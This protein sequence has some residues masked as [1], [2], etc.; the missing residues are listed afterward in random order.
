VR[1]LSSALSREGA[2]G[3]R[4]V[5]RVL[6]GE[7]AHL[8]A[9]RSVPVRTFESLA[10]V[11]AERG[12]VARPRILG[13]GRVQI[14]ISPSDATVDPAGRT[15]FVAGD[16][17]VVVSPGETVAIGEIARRAEGR[18]LGTRVLDSQRTRQ[19]RVLLLS[20]EVEGPD[21]AS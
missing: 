4:G 2:G 14:E 21:D 18:E 6:D 11:E 19:E 7:V 16:T 1:V 3:F 9:G 15:R 20:V 10:V 5:V 13:D 12:F 17:T 8:G